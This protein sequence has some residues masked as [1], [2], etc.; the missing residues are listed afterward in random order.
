MQLTTTASD[1]NAESQRHYNIALEQISRSNYAAALREMAI[2]LQGAPNNAVYMS[3]YA[4]CLARAE[5]DF[6]TAVQVCKRAAAMLRDDITIQVNLGRI[7]SLQG[8]R[9]LAHETFLRAWERDTR[10]PGPAAELARLGI[11]R[12][13]VVPFMPRSSWCNRY[14][15]KLRATIARVLS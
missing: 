3:Y 14:L 4:L 12:P 5:K 15:G 1:A 9:E 8:N 10:H 11:R 6:G 13:S 2:A 7:Y